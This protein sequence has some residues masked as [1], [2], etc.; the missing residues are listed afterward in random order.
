M[1]LTT[2]N[3]T[4][5]GLYSGIGGGP[6]T[7][8]KY[9]AVFGGNVFVSGVLSKSSGTFRIDHPQDPEN[10]YLVHS[11]VESPDMMNVYNGNIIT[12][13]DGKALVSLPAYFETLNRD[14][15]YQLT[16]I[17]Q[18]AQAWVLEEIKENQFKIQTDKPNVKVSWQ[19]TGVR[20]DPWA[21]QHP[22]IPE[23]EKLPQDKGK[24]L[25]P[26]VYGKPETQGIHYHKPDTGNIKKP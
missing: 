25:N 23:E 16:V 2:N 18:P 1:D 26:E 5:Y 13:A 20:Q 7:G 10:K 14:F 22:V 12:G 21:V 19:V 24:Y 6:A 15:R 17:G 11:F 3:T 9:A 4:G 8:T